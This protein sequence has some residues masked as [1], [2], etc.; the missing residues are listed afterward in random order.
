MP[1]KNIQ[2]HAAGAI[3][4]A[5]ISDV[6]GLGPHWYYNLA[7]LRNDFE[8]AVL[9]EVNGGGQ[10]QVRAI[11]TGALTGAQTGLSGIPRRFTA[12]IEKADDLGKLA[13]DLASKVG[14]P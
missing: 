13:A 5:F 12:G 3:M 9:Q 14:R 2:D 8:S 11:L 1:V 4:G 10:N 7:E 6:L